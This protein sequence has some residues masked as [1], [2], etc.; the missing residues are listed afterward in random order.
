MGVYPQSIPS[1]GVHTL[2]GRRMKLFQ[3]LKSFIPTNSGA[4]PRKHPQVQKVETI[5]PVPYSVFIKLEPFLNS[6]FKLFKMFLLFLTWWEN[7]FVGLCWVRKEERRMTP[8]PCDGFT[9]LEII[10]EIQISNFQMCFCFYFNSQKPYPKNIPSHGRRMEE[11]CIPREKGAYP[12]WSA[13]KGGSLHSWS[14][15][16][17]PH[18]A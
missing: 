10:L 14:Q 8:V 6:K 4:F 11:R 3:L 12:A 1:F 17:D 2:H 5:S 13:E 7:D 18:H 15:D 9:K 16:S